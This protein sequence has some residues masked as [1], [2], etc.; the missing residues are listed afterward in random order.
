MPCDVDPPTTILSIDKHRE[1]GSEGSFNLYFDPW[2][3]QF[4]E[5]STAAPKCYIDHHYAGDSMGF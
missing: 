5:S 4:M 3:L 2:S 1:E